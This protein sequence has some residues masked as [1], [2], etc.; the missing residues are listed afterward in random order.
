MPQIHVDFHEQGVNSPYYFAPA[1]EP[2]HEVITPWQ[3]DF[4]KTIG[5]NH[6]RYFDEKGWLYFTKERFDLLYPSYGDTYPIYNGAIGMTYEQAGGGPGGLGV[7]IATGDTL[8]LVDRVQHHFTT[9]LSTLEVAS[10]NASKLLSEY[11]KFFTDATNGHAGSYQ[12][13]II[14]N[15][16]SDAERVSSLLK[17]LDKNK[18][19]YTAGRQG[20]ARGYSYLSG[21]EEGLTIDGDDILVSS[22]QPQGTMVKVLFEPN[23]VL[24]DSATYDITAWSLPYVFGLNAYASKEKIPGN[25]Y[26]A[27]VKVTNTDANSY[28]YIIRWNGLPTVQLVGQLLN[29]GIKLR[30]SEEPFTIG[31][32]SF[33]RGSVIVLKTSNTYQPNLWNSVKELANQYNVQLTPVASGFVDKGYDFGSGSVRPLIKRKVAL[34][35]GEGVNANAA[36][37][38]WHFFEQQINYP[39]TL[40]NLNDVPRMTWSDF[41][42]V[43]IPDGNYRF[44]TE[45]A[46]ADQ[47]KNWISGGGE[48]IA[49]ESA[50]AQLSRLDWSIKAKKQADTGSKNPYD[51]LRKYESRERD[52]IS[53]TTPGSIYK[54]ELDN[55]HP[56]AFG[57]PNYYYTL[58][59]DDNIY[60]FIKEGGWN[61]GV[62]RKDNQVAGFVGKNLQ[63]KL[64]DGL[65]FGVQEIGRGNVVYLADD[66]LF[67]NFWENGKLL[68]SN[69]VFLVGQ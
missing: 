12:T 22:A 19:Q 29:K 45:K 49:M 69:A 14:K 63:K 10:Q 55:T 48:L 64:Q 2:Y 1:A 38:V 24:S 44:L 37:E 20:S 27:P 65:L 25:T 32:Q 47:L 62:L 43:I 60:E 59:Q 61:V 6:A 23:A 28:G 15:N 11:Q 5:K 7:T 40:V 36:G 26:T 16:P 51:A 21:K 8:T 56:L 3:R 39:V 35:T 34:I 68:F 42:V 58:K 33:D 13:Y 41:D 67:R 30:Y 53:N 46:S 18:I 17:L 66:V 57:F 50:V 54:V 9:S 52:V 31:G 4:Q